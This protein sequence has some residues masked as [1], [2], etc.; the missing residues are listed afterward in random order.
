MLVFRSEQHVDRWCEQ[1]NRPR[2]WHPELAARLAAGEGMVQRSPESRLAA[3]K[4]IGGSG[5]L[6][7]N[8]TQRGVLETISQ[9]RR[10]RYLRGFSNF[11]VAIWLPLSYNCFFASGEA[12]GQ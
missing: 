11:L 7:P 5:R 12:S 4:R 9:S 10:S 2:G 8:W 6:R 1:W 3:E